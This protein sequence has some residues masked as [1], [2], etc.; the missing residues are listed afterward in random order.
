MTHIVKSILSFSNVRMRTK[1]LREEAI[2][3]HNV[4]GY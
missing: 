1:V 4:E 2:V 3:D